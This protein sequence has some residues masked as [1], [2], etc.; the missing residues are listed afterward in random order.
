MPVGSSAQA[1]AIARPRTRGQDHRLLGGEH[2]GQRGRGELADAVA[3]DDAPT[4][5]QS[6]GARRRAGR[7]RPAAAG[8]R[9][10]PDLVGVGLGAEVHQVEPGERGPP[11]QPGLGAGQVEPGGEEAGLLGTLTGSDDGEHVYPL[12]RIPAG[13]AVAGADETALPNFVGFLQRSADVVRRNSMCRCHVGSVGVA[14]GAT[15]PAGRRSAR[16]GG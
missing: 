7:R 5:S 16:S 4:S 12:C 10:V 2:A 15:G 6:A 3:G 9:G 14:A 1:A 13:H 11:A 8:S